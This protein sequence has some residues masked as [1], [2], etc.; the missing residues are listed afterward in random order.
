MSVARCQAEVDSAEFTQWLAYSKIEPFGT[1]MEDLRAGV[2]AAA[3]YNV[4][5]SPKA[6]PEP[7]GP[8][9]V[10]PWLGGVSKPAANEPILLPDVVAQSNL[11][12]AALFGQAPN[13]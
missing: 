3:I 11:M 2:V 1:E 13:G 8:S 9:D 5:R 6:R 4:N 12:R 7:F 10:I